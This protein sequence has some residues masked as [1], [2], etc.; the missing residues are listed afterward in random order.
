MLHTKPAKI[1][2]PPP[3][4]IALIKMFFARFSL[5]IL[6]LAAVIIIVLGQADAKLAELVRMRVL[7]RLLPMMS[8]M[9]WPVD[10]MIGLGG[11]ISGIISLEEEN[12]RLVQENMKLRQ[13]YDLSQH[14]QVENEE[15]RRLLHTAKDPAVSFITARVVTDVSG[16]YVR[17]ALIN[18]GQKNGV[19]K[20]QIVIN[21]QG[22]VGR[23]IEIGEKS[24]RI[25]LLS[26]LNSRI[27]VITSESRERC[28][29]AGDNSESLKIVYLPGD[30]KVKVGER[31]FTSGDGG[32]FPADLLVGTIY[33]ATDRAFYIKPAVE[34]S[35]LGYVQVVGN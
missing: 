3:H 25:L 19:K 33:A 23:I 8:V 15:L 12:K 2:P 4:G 14:I 17:S 22:A 13:H 10:Y 21:E 11:K 35:R 9:T 34:W 1:L 18:V 31:V 26:D 32:M 7:D 5:G 16:P 29:A 6:C 30:N 28:I 27:P 24:A 20:D